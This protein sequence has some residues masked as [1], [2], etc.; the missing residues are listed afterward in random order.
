MAPVVSVHKQIAISN[1]KY[2]MNDTSFSISE[3]GIIIDFILLPSNFSLDIWEWYW[4]DGAKF[5]S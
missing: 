4:F 5:G 1:D 3:V 2:F